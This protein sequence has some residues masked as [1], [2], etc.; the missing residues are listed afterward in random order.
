MFVGAIAKGHS[1]SRTAGMAHLDIDHNGDSVWIL[2][3]TWIETDK[4]IA[5]PT[6]NRI[7]A[8]NPDRTSRY[9]ESTYDKGEEG[10]A[11]GDPVVSAGNNL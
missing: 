6:N 8:I 11:H 5:I 10:G 3:G 4:S 9:K 1:T 7:L 2:S